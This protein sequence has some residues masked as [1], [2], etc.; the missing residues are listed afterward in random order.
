M[1]LVVWEI[2]KLYL[3]LCFKF[4]IYLLLVSQLNID[5]LVRGMGSAFGTLDRKNPSE[6]LS[7]KIIISNQKLLG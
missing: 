5:W 3:F 6:M 2:A 1:F 7:G 4:G